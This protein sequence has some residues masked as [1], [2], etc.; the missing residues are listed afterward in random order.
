MR[1][2][3]VFQEYA[4]YFKTVT[5]YSAYFKNHPCIVRISNSVRVYCVFQKRVS[6]VNCIFM[7]ILHIMRMTHMMRILRIWRIMRISIFLDMI[8]LR[9]QRMLRIERILRK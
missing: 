9:I 2:S 6:C 5:E 3:C 1:I 4:A 7:R 8:F